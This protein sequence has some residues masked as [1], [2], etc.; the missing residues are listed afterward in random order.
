MSAADRQPVTAGFDAAGNWHIPGGDEGGRFARRGTLGWSSAKALAIR[1]LRGAFARDLSKA[2]PDGVWLEAADDYLSRLGISKGQAV[3]VRFGDAAHALIDAVHPDGQTRPVKVKWERF[4]DRVPLTENE[5]WLPDK[6]TRDLLVMEDADRLDIGRRLFDH[7]LGDGY[8]SVATWTD[9]V[10]DPTGVGLAVHG[11]VRHRGTT[12]GHWTRRIGRAGRGNEGAVVVVNDILAVAANDKHKAHRGKGVGLRFVAASNAA[13]A[14]AGADDVR[15]TAVTGSNTN[16]AYTWARAGYRWERDGKSIGAR[17]LKYDP[18]NEVGRR[19]VEMDPTDPTYPQPEDVARDPKGAKFLKG[20]DL[21]GPLGTVQ[22]SGVLHLNQSTAERVETPTVARNTTKGDLGRGQATAARVRDAGGTGQAVVADGYLARHGHPKGA[23]VTVTYVDDTYADVHPATPDG[24]TVRSKWSHFAD[25]APEPAPERVNRFDARGVDEALP[26]R[27]P[28]DDTLTADQREALVGS[29]FDDYSPSPELVGW[30]K[31]HE[32]DAPTLYRGVYWDDPAERDAATEK[33]MGDG[34]TILDGGFYPVEAYS[35]RRQV[36]EAFAEQGETGAVFV[37]DGAKAADLAPLVDPALHPDAADEREWLVVSPQHVKFDRYEDSPDGF[38]RTF[39]GHVV[40]DDAPEPAPRPADGHPDT[41]TGGDGGPLRAPAGY[42]IEPWDRD[43]ETPAEMLAVTAEREAA[44]RAAT[45]HHG[46]TN[47]G[48]RDGDHWVHVGTQAAADHRAAPRHPKDVDYDPNAGPGQVYDVRLKP[49]ARIAPVMAEDDGEIG[50]TP[51]TG[52][53]DVVPYWNST[54]DPGSMSLFVRADALEPADAVPKL[55]HDEAIGAVGGVTQRRRDLA[56]RADMERLAAAAE[57]RPAVRMRPDDFAA[58]VASGRLKTMHETGTSNGDMSTVAERVAIERDRLGVPDDTPAASRPVYGTVATQEGLRDAEDYGEVVVLLRPEAVAGRVSFSVGDTLMS[59]VAPIFPADV[60]AASDDRL[61]A[62]VDGDFDRIA[63]VE[64]QIHGGVTTADIAAVAVPDTP[65]PDGDPPPDYRKLLDDAGLTDVEVRTYRADWADGAG[66]FLV[67]NGDYSVLTGAPSSPNTRDLV[68][69]PGSDAET[70]ADLLYNGTTP[71]GHK[72][73]RRSVTDRTVTSGPAHAPVTHRIMRFNA[74]VYDD[75]PDFVDADGNPGQAHRFAHTITVAPGVDG[76]PHISIFLEG[77]GGDLWL[78]AD[79]Y[80]EQIAERIGADQITSYSPDTSTIVRNDDLRDFIAEGWQFHPNNDR[81]SIRN[82]GVDL[83]YDHADIGYVTAWRDWDGRTVDDLPPPQAVLDA[84][85]ISARSDATARLSFLGIKSLTGRHAVPELPREG[86]WLDWANA[87][88]LPDGTLIEAEVDDQPRQYKVFSGRFIG[89]PAADAKTAAEEIERLGLGPGEGINPK[90][91]YPTQVTVRR[92]QAA[93]LPDVPPPPTPVEGVKVA[94]STE[95]ARPFWYP[96]QVVEGADLAKLP[97]GVR[98]RAINDRDQPLDFD[99]GHDMLVTS[100]GMARP[101]HDDRYSVVERTD[102]ALGRYMLT[103]VPERPVG[104]SSDV[105]PLPDD[106]NVRVRNA[107]VDTARELK[108]NGAGVRSV[109]PFAAG[110]I[111][112]ADWVLGV[113]Q[114]RD[115]RVAAPGAVLEAGY[116]QWQA[117]HFP[118]G[119]GAEPYGPV[120]RLPG[121]SENYNVVWSTTPIEGVEPEVIRSS[122]PSGAIAD[123]RGILLFGRGSNTPIRWDTPRPSPLTDE[124]V[125]ER[126]AKVGPP[127]PVALNTIVTYGETTPDTPAARTRLAADWLANPSYPYNGMDVRRMRTPGPTIDGPTRTVRITTDETRG[128]P[129]IE[130]SPYVIGSPELDLAGW[131]DDDLVLPVDDPRL[132]AVIDRVWWQ[133]TIRNGAVADIEAQYIAVGEAT[134]IVPGD[135]DPKIARTLESASNMLR[136]KV[137][138]PDGTVPIRHDGTRFVVDPGGISVP[139]ADVH[140]LSADGDTTVAYVNRNAAVAV[141]GEDA[142]TPDYR[143][144][145]EW[146]WEEKVQHVAAQRE[147]LLRGMPGATLDNMFVPP[148]KDTDKIETGE[149][150]LRPVHTLQMERAQAVAAH[151]AAVADLVMARRKQI[152]EDSARDAE[153]RGGGDLGARIAPNH[154]KTL[155]KAIEEIVGSHLPVS[156]TFNAEE[157]ALLGTN[158]TVKLLL[159]RIADGTGTVNYRPARKPGIDSEQARLD[160]MARVTIYGAPT[161]S[162]ID[163]QR[164]PWMEV[165][166]DEQGGI[167]KVT[168]HPDGYHQF[169]AVDYAHDYVLDDERE[170]EQKLIRRLRRV[171]ADIDNMSK[172]DPRPTLGELAA[173]ETMEALGIDMGTDGSIMV[174]EK[175]DATTKLGRSTSRA[176]Y[177]AQVGLNVYPRDWTATLPTQIIQFPNDDK[178]AL[179]GGDNTGGTLIRIADPRKYPRHRDTVVHEFGHSMEASVPGLRAAEAWYLMH[180]VLDRQ[181]EKGRVPV[182]KN[183]EIDGRDI[184]VAE[185]GFARPY[186]GRV[187]N[188]STIAG[189]TDYEVFTVAMESILNKTATTEADR[190]AYRQVDEGLFQWVLG[191]LTLIRPFTE[192]AK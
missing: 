161:R 139:S 79:R 52:D 120:W 160:S 138:A 145:P 89:F 188:E 28:L 23:T 181:S 61:A 114:N 192:E 40:A 125:A 164:G 59:E 32:T 110:A 70:L 2:N 147:K 133:S 123:D 128:Y 144:D 175:H 66:G 131:A 124:Q 77:G 63:N 150:P 90:G 162:R 159:E 9:A 102:G 108:V 30:A 80:A 146:S 4:A 10:W 5:R 152:E 46:T 105:K 81:Y 15:V 178:Y 62:A 180:R 54:E 169:D 3:R 71:G 27:K 42:V 153:Y 41:A 182:R 37:V 168:V 55:S 67:P 107:L 140:Y 47:P 130:K 98:Y 94:P 20:D 14:L 157:E 44:I 73:T 31:A 143:M 85:N 165:T 109:E 186:A 65:N 101:A 19:L 36:G 7:D 148:S 106:L 176:A 141:L 191:I 170:A 22:W 156:G 69:D 112:P 135:V 172:A 82:V 97:N 86:G 184:V 49:D 6:I 57:E 24:R 18:G 96:G 76:Q 95:P 34:R 58:V 83:A 126:L 8:T 50:W 75:N 149:D 118:R 29:W 56:D 25:D 93:P 158:P 68:L 99:G 127:P 64:T 154:A 177:A 103:V 136:S 179:G 12:I 1:A 43:G 113:G 38:V 187:Y 111:H 129:V 132:P 137:E 151:G 84:A 119:V 167:H 72:V 51:P 78:D 183:G 117:S 26:P 185:G 35:D 33:L 155:T 100:K 45:W 74:D 88:D 116:A 91:Q 39:Y 121:R 134:A 171:A 17:L 13:A 104:A 11:E 189:N 87:A 60:P 163:Q 173:I 122:D 190:S 16:G 174:G 92:Y 53:W 21:R 48:W 166:V 115:R 142:V